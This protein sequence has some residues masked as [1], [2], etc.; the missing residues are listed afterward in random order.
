MQRSE[1]RKLEDV[2]RHELDAILCCGCFFAEI[3]K[4]GEEYEPDSGRRMS[5]SRS[6]KARSDTLFTTFIDRC[7]IFTLPG[8]RLRKLR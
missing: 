1:A 7:N 8:N 2:P 3:R 4:D 6:Y 5:D